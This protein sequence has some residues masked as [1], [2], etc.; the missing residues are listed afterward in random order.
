[1]FNYENK[2][3]FARFL[4]DEWKQNRF[5]SR[6]QGRELYFV[7]GRKR[8][9]LVSI[10]GEKGVS[11]VEELHSYQEEADTK[12]LLHILHTSKHSSDDATVTVRSP[13]TDVF[14]LLLHFHEKIHQV[15]FDNDSVDKWRLLD[16]KNYR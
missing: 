16:E 15:F 12:I 7:C 11:E 1:L 9:E 10:N 14:V 13:D 2:S 4:Q 5:A 8:M 3:R 6:S